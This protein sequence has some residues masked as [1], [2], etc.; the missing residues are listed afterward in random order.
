M[1]P[2]PPATAHGIED[3]PSGGWIPLYDQT[4]PPEQRPRAFGQWLVQ[5]F[6][7]PELDKKDCH[8]L[9]YKVDA[10]DKLPTF[11]GM[12][13]PEVLTKVDFTAGP[14]ADNHVADRH[15]Q[16][17]HRVL[18]AKAF[19][20]SATR[21]QWNDVPFVVLYGEEAP[22]TIVWAAWQLQAEAEKTGLPIRFKNIP[23]ANHFVSCLFWSV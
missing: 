5:Y 12:P 13:F 19:F 8:K 6:P 17:A 7:H 21:T 22:W 2:D 23:G 1:L 18:R 11:T 4:L 3:P 10:P 14:A 16:P 9:V 20:N 15:F